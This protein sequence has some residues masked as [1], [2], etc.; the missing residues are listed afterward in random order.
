[1]SV[2]NEAERE[3]KR[4][5]DRR[6]H[7]GR[8]HD[9]AQD[10]RHGGAD[11]EGKDLVGPGQGDAGML[12]VEGEES[13]AD[14]EIEE[15]GHQRADGRERERALA[16]PS[17]LH[18]E[19]TLHQVVIRAEGGHGADESVQNGEP[20][21]IGVRE[22]P[23]PEIRR[24]R[25]GTPVDDAEATGLRRRAEHGAQP[26]SIRQTRNATVRAPPRGRCRPGRH[27]SRSRP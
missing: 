5:V 24:A 10:H 9:A 26:P 11:E 27:W 7:D 13:G 18:G 25:R 8:E 22:H 21:D 12:G 17:R 15:Q 4:R 23:M 20:E 14:G 19:E 6:E 1:M 2:T 3:P 16:L